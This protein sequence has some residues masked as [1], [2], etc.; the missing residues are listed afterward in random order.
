MAPPTPA[1]LEGTTLDAAALRRGIVQRRGTI[2]LLLAW[3]AV[4]AGVAAWLGVR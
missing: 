4:M 2:G 1:Q 3:A